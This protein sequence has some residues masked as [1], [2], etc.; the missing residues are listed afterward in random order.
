MTSQS[1]SPSQLLLQFVD[2][3]GTMRERNRLRFRADR[4]KDDQAG[5]NS[6]NSIDQGTDSRKQSNY[7]RK[8]QSIISLIS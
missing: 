7:P 5:F 4:S 6:T 2:A 3:A 1:N 8:I